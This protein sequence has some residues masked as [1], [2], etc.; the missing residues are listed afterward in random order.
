[1]AELTQKGLAGMP[2]ASVLA[3]GVAFA[4][5]VVVS[6]GARGRLARVLPSAAAMG[7]GFFVPAYYAVAICLGALLAAG[8]G[9]L[10]PS[11][12]QTTQAAGAGAIVGESL[13][14]VLLSA[15]MAFGLMRPPG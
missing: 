5:G 4:L 8:V 2:R 15:L 13:L 3:T 7:I 6:A 14:S 9:R 12:T 11:A 10:R 1:V